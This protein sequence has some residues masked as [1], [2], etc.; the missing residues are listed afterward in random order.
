[1]RKRSTDYSSRRSGGDEENQR[2][3]RDYRSPTQAPPRQAPTSYAQEPP[4]P[5]RTQNSYSAPPAQP[6]QPRI[7]PK[8]QSVDY[9]SRRSGG[10]EENLRRSRDFS[11]PGSKR[12][13][14]SIS[15]NTL[16]QVPY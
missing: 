14:Y 11:S 15:L 3:S 7:V 9:A 2:R 5:S 1:M 10:Q 8:R 6:S 13:T 16:S 4:V 12:G